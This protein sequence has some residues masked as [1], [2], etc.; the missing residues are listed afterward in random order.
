MLASIL[1]QLEVLTW[2]Q[3]YPNVRIAGSGVMWLFLAESKVPSV[4]SVMALTN[5]KTTVNLGDVA[6]LMRR[7]TL[8]ASRQ[9][10]ANHAHTLSNALIAG[11]TT[12]LTPTNVHS[13][14]TNS[15]ENGNKRNMLRSMKTESSQFALQ[16]AANRKYNSEKPQDFFTK[17]S[18]E[19]FHRQ[20]YSQDPVTLWY[21]S[22][23][24]TPL[25]CHS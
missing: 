11:R 19:P 5:P 10:K 22:Y 8:L 1:P 20:H 12:K 17:C 21:S 24:R 9:R 3:A 15:T 13:G 23:P 4:L 7:W 2:T 14:D 6:R 16:R 25:V 18:Q